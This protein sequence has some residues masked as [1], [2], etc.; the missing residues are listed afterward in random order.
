MLYLS[1]RTKKNLIPRY[2]IKK[3]KIKFLY[4]SIRTKK[5]L[6]PQHNNFYFLPLL[7]PLR[8]LRSRRC[9]FSRRTGAN[10]TC[11]PL[12]I[13]YAQ[14]H[15]HSH[16]VV[17]KDTRVCVCNEPTLY[18]LTRGVSGIPPPHPKQGWISDIFFI[19]KTW[20]LS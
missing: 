14:Y 4:L 17:R 2:K 19:N 13:G 12:F 8:P 5:N 6:I 1:I 15:Y 11:K 18:G 16:M 9:W 7:P 3:I 20:V 10:T